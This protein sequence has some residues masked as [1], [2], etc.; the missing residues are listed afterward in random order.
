[1]TTFGRDSEGY[2]TF[3]GVRLSELLSQASVGTPAYFYDLDGI[4]AAALALKGA[5]EERDHLIAYAVKANSAGSIVRTLG[6]LGI[7][8]CLVSG[9]E[10]LVASGAG[11]SPGHMVMNGV[12]K[13]DAELD[14]AISRGLLGI[15]AESLEELD[16]I[17]ARA[18]AQGRR[19]RVALR[20][21]PGVEIDSHSHIATGH[22]AAK[23]GIPR[24]DAGLAFERIDRH[25]E[26]LNCVGISTHVGSMLSAP[27]AYVKSARTV[28][29]LAQSRLSD[30]GSLEYINFG[31]GFG[32]DYGS[33]QT[34]P[35]AE[36]AR[37]ALR[38]AEQCGLEGL[39][40]VVEPGR[41]LVAPHGVLVSRVVQSKQ[42]RER[43]W[44]MIDAGMNDLL[45]PALYGA[46]HRIEPL[47]RAPAGTEW[48]VVG[49]ICESSDDFGTHRIGDVPGAVA[50]RDVGA[51]GFCMASE[52]N[53][54]PMP[55]EVFVQGGR[56]QHVS[57]SPGRQA[58]V[59]RRLNA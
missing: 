16:R 29:E 37:A 15:Q 34:A 59:E 27:D 26:S 57:D 24:R 43:R 19:A 23:F 28:C 55:A 53:G 42:G 4:S 56:V 48:R 17:A 39:K 46:L 1:M 49:P 5:L 25:A 3:G 51:Y 2:A 13:S 35:L 47:D 36:F 14:L 11:I 33:G 8:A 40:L 21:N 54:R 45:R 44:L 18:A 31:G 9:G 10:L 50:I 30:G 12:A 41:S 52:Y 32:V 20:I 6:A 22:D 38:L 7:G 58:W